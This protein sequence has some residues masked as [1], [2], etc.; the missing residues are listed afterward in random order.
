MSIG[1]ATRGAAVWG[2]RNR[3]PWRML[4]TAPLADRRARLRARRSIGLAAA[5]AAS[6]PMAARGRICFALRGESMTQERLA[7][8]CGKLKV[9]HYPILGRATS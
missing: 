2:W 4:A 3:V 9:V 1:E 6:G 8:H 7:L 5:T